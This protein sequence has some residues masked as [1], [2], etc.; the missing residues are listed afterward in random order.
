M[1]KPMLK[2]PQTATQRTQAD[3]LLSAVRQERQ[4]GQEQQHEEAR[5]LEKRNTD[6]L[7]RKTRSKAYVEA[8]SKLDAGGHV[9]N[10]KQ[11]EEILQTIRQEFPDL[12]V[13]G[14]LLGVV[15]ICY[16][17]EPYEVHSLAIEGGILEHYQ[18][19]QAL[20][21]RLEKARGIALRGGYQFIEVYSDCCR[22]IGK[23]GS[24]AVIL[25]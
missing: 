24:V 17:G 13:Y 12:E 25:E 2:T 5:M 4:L 10:Q 1:P 14:L 7:L 21:S 3:S 19:G 8:L 15:A 16:L 11:I 6:R 18:R 9:Q 22:A 23:N 20:P